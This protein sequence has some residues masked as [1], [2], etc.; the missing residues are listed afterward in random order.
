MGVADTVEVRRARPLLGTWV[1]VRVGARDRDTALAAAERALGAVERVQALMSVHSAS[2]EVSRLNREAARGPVRVDPWT[3]RILREADRISRASG[4]LF[5]ISVGGAL[6]D[7]GQLPNFH[8][9]SQS[10]DPAASYRDIQLRARDRSVRFRRELAID[11]GGIAKGFAVDL[12]VR[13]ARGRGV[14]SVAVE[15]GGDLR[16]E[17]CVVEPVFVRD[18][19]H[20]DRVRPLFEAKAAA[21]AS[22]GGR[23]AGRP[24]RDGRLAVPILDRLGTSRSARVERGEVAATVHGRSC[25]EADALTKVALLAPAAEARRVL[26]RFG[27]RAW[28]MTA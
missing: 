18:P 27:A 22:S 11:L 7:R 6:R 14:S 24:A 26:A 19:W 12:A 15:A 3:F 28:R 1:R 17:S 10:L 9:D 8:G 20:P 13:A 21:I 25:L 16:F 23:L 5:D 2:S 4:G